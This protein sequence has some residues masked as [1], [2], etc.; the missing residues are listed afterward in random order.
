MG[1]TIHSLPEY[2][3]CT[4]TG[5][6]FRATGFNGA[7]PLLKC[8]GATEW[9]VDEAGAS[10]TE[11]MN[12]RKE[13]IRAMCERMWNIHICQR[14]SIN[15]MMGTR[16]LECDDMYYTY[17][18]IQKPVIDAIIMKVN[19]NSFVRDWDFY[20]IIRG[21]IEQGFIPLSGGETRRKVHDKSCGTM[22]GHWRWRWLKS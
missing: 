5:F 10:G 13:G 8:N 4:G 6:K 1:C 21:C 2:D 7:P 14:S 17:G 20:F 15:G 22:Y 19:N 16:S 9:R 12:G 11:W 3:S 18:S